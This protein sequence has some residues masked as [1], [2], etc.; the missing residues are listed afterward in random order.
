MTIFQSI[1]LGIVQGLTEFIPVSSS[2]HLALLAYFLHWRIPP[3]V[4]FVFDVLVQFATLGAVIVYYARDLWNL[5][6]A[7]IQVIQSRKVKDPEFNLLIA[8]VIATLPVVILGIPLKKLIA[9]AFNSP[10]FV[11][12]ALLVTAFLLYI[13]EKISQNRQTHSLVTPLDAL[14]IGIFQVFATFPGISRSGATISGGV[15]RKLDRPA[16]TRFAFLLAIPALTGAGLV[17]LLDLFK[18]PGLNQ[19]VPIILPGFIVSFLVG[20]I[21]INWLIKYL[22]NHSLK[23]FALYCAV[24]GIFTLGYVLLR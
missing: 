11:G 18:L 4:A 10:A 15:M 21:S 6:L 19:L 23:V 20:L 7:F 16:A 3:D 17:S 5:L 22:Q 8:L 12:G 9:D 24:L 14:I 1:L 2:A 13:A